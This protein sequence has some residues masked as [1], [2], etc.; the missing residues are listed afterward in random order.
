M[1]AAQGAM[2]SNT[3]DKIFGTPSQA[4]KQK[5]EGGAAE[6][7]P[8]FHKRMVRSRSRRV[9]GSNVNG[10][11]TNDQVEG[12]GA[13]PHSHLDD[14]L[15]SQIAN[16]KAGPKSVGKRSAVSAA[17]S[18]RNNALIEQAANLAQYKKH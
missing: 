17:S 13:K 14:F 16:Q 5:A 11:L 6:E 9:G 3:A 7:H 2:A 8:Y 1:G 12:D 15:R 4:E 10:L 18:R